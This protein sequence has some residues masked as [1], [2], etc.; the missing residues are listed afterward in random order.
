[1]ASII[2][3][4]E[5]VKSQKLKL[6]CESY[7]V[8]KLYQNLVKE[9]GGNYLKPNESYSRKRSNSSSELNAANN[10]VGTSN[11]EFIHP[12]NPVKIRKTS[13]DNNISVKNKFA[14]LASPELSNGVET[15]ESDEYQLPSHAPPTTPRNT[16]AQH[17]PSN[18][19]NPVNGNTSAKKNEKPPPIFLCNLD[20][21]EL[22]NNLITSGISNNVFTVKKTNDTLTVIADNLQTHDDIKKYFSTNKVEFYTFT[23]RSQK[24]INLVLKGIVGNYNADDILNEFKSLNIK[25]VEIKKISQIKFS[26]KTSDLNFL[27]QLS[28]SSIISEIKK[29]NRIKCQ[30]ITWEH[31]RKSKVYQCK[32]CQLVG[33]T[34][35]NCNLPYRCVKCEN[36]HK[37]GDCSITERVDKT[38]LYCVNCKEKG[39]PA[40]FKGCP[41]MSFAQDLFN[42]NKQKIQLNR[43]TK[44]NKISRV[45]NNQLSYSNA[46]KNQYQQQFPVLINPNPVNNQSTAPNANNIN[47]APSVENLLVGFKNEILEAIKINTVNLQTAINANS[48][49]IDYLYRHL[50]LKHNE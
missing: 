11:N 40:N 15:M 28:P 47:S 26:N 17:R 2:K 34:S 32:N 30:K 19:R 43:K 21:K 23:P 42:N 29:I 25:D 39:H 13:S 12:K 22:T 27:V 37:P 8:A 9:R 4:D 48:T 49:K 1:M 7:N 31:L 46:F 24:P 44:L 18:I 33:H 14:T 45:V 38:E 16:E 5:I 36:N 6:G 10:S 35:S 50:N 3:K 41:F 20:I